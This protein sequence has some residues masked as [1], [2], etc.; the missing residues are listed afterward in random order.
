RCEPST[1]LV[2]NP[3]AKAF[4]L[5]R[6]A[7][8]GALALIVVLAATALAGCATATPQTVDP[9][10]EPVVSATPTPSFL[11]ELPEWAKETHW[12]IYPEDFEC[13]GTEGCPN[14][15]RFSF[16]EPGPVLPENVE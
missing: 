4:T 14:D 12:L 1:D 15:Y 8:T 13:S 16:G 3:M 5:R 11:T 7:P 9:A 6:R 10:A 2:R